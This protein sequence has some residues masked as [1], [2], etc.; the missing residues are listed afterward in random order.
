MRDRIADPY[1]AQMRTYREHPRSLNRRLV[2]D[3]VRDHSEYVELAIEALA[4]AAPVTLALVQ[5]HKAIRR[6]PARN[7]WPFIR[8]TK[9]VLFVRSADTGRDSP[10]PWQRTK[11]GN[12]R[13]ALPGVLL[14]SPWLP[15]VRRDVR[16]RTIELQRTR[17]HIR[18][19]A[20]QDDVWS[21][22]LHWFIFY[23][24]RRAR[25]LLEEVKVLQGIAGPESIA[26]LD[27]WSDDP[28]RGS[29]ITLRISRNTL[30]YRDGPEHC[31][32]D[33]SAALTKPLS[34]PSTPDRDLKLH[35]VRAGRQSYSP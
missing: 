32:I 10:W 16:N 12:M 7:F 5:F 13:Y 8:K 35:L 2:E 31:E 20:G 1:D 4:Q 24:T 34:I 23:G 25:W 15:N 28:L 18:S 6:S 22:N 33:I 21:Q 9:G 14:F 26:A 29:N 11:T 17:A 19:M 30:V 3:Y 27:R